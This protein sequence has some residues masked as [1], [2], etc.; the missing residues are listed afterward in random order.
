MQHSQPQSAVSIPDHEA[1]IDTVRAVACLMVI[2]LHAAAFYVINEDVGSTDWAWANAIDS[3]TRVCVPLFF[4]VTG[5]LFLGGRQPKARHILRVVSSIAVYSGLALAL[6][7]AGTGQFPLAKIAALPFQPA[8]YHLWY[9]YALIGIYLLGSI[10]TVRPTASL[11]MLAALCLLMF[12]INDSGLAPQGSDIALDGASIIYLLFAMSGSVLGQLLSNLDPMQ[13][14]WG[15]RGALVTFWLCVI[16]ITVMT[17]QASAAAG[18]FISTYYSYTHPLVIAAA[19]SCFTWLRLAS[20]GRV[21]RPLLRRVAEHSLAIYGVHA[22]ALDGLRGLSALA[23]LPAGIEIL[24]S[25]LIVT[26]VSYLVARGLRACDP[27]KLFT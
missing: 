9:L 5:Y 11:S 27:R 23:D 10:I 14:H 19:L 8:Y 13:K 26:L 20:P 2:L 21:L 15:R 3:A 16:L 24:W 18:R 6:I 7:W 25:F 22:L 17:H 1:W 12:V 4:M